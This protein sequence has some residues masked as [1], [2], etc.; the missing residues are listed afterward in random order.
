MFHFEALQQLARERGEQLQR[1]AFAERLASAARWR[2]R[3]RRRMT[4]TAGVEFGPAASAR[5]VGNRP[6]VRYVPAERS[7]HAIACCG[8]GGR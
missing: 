5:R 6:G 2:H 7:D 1:E 3:P 8:S 4:P